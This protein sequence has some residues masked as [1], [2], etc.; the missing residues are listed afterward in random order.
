MSKRIIWIQVAR[1]ELLDGASFDEVIYL[2]RDDGCSLDEA[3]ELVEL[4]SEELREERTI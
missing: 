3:E 1:R 4:A 2:L